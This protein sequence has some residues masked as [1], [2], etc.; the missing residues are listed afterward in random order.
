MCGF[1]AT[2][3]IN[4]VQRMLER[5]DHRGPDGNYYMRSQDIAIGH[6]LL[7]ISGAQQHQP[8]VTKKGN[9]FAFNGEAYD[10]NIEND[11]V[12]MA[13]GFEMFGLRFLSQTDWHGSIVYYDKTTREVT[14]IRDHFGAKPLWMYKKGEEITYDYGYDVDNYEDHPCRCGSKKCV[15][16]IVSEEQWPKLKKLIR[17]SH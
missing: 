5:Q 4:N 12:F 9:L 8:I 17:S 11:T 15:G 13:N 14:A 10:S 2:T 7:D 1:V 16:Y 6:A 3:D